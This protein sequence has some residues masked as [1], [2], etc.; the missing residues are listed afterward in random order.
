[1]TE[2]EVIEAAAQ[3]VDTSLSAIALYASFTFA[4]LT[5]AYF[6][7]SNLRPFQARM[8]SVLYVASAGI[9]TSS[10]F[11]TVQAWTHMVHTYPTILND[12]AVLDFGGWH[13]CLSAVMVAGIFASLYFLHDIR[14]AK[15]TQSD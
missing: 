4:Y 14:S 13:Y 10:S 6:I 5:A 12:L 8:V 11:A 1:M 15:D 2:A 9:M 7:G 3:Y